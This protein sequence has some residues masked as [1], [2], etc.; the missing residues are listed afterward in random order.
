[1]SAATLPDPLALA[2]ST[3]QAC[4]SR[5][6]APF[7]GSLPYFPDGKP[8]EYAPPQTSPEPIPPKTILF[9]W[10]LGGGLGH[11]MQILPLAQDLAKAGHTVFAAMRNIDRAGSILGQ[12]GVRFLP[13]A[14]SALAPACRQ[15]ATFPELLLNVGFSSDTALFARACAWRNLFKLAKP[16][17]VIF[18]HAPT[19]LLASRRLP[20]R[21]VLTGDKKVQ[22]NLSLH[23]NK[24]IPAR[25]L[26]HPAV[27]V[28]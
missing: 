7:D 25:F 22:V 6:L 19:A 4:S 26:L 3:A 27:Y 17:L 2:A 18:D 21:R 28:W 8:E 11:M 24:K 15:T 13:V 20:L 1:M 23:P 12:A 10:E 5:K 14:C 9:A 16:D